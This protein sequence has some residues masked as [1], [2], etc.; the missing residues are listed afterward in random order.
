MQNFVK[1]VEV[2]PRDGLQNEA[3]LVPSEIKIAFINLLSGC[4][5][6]VIEATSFV[7]AKAI[8]QLA[9]NHEVLSAIHKQAGVTY[10][11]L[12]P[13]IQGFNA[14]LVAKAQEVSVFTAAS[15]SFTQKNINCSVEESL[16]RFAPIL[17][18][19][20][21]H[22]IA[23]RA[24]ISCAL[25]CPYEGKIAP[26]WV[27]ELA[28]RLF[29]MGCYEISLGDTIGIATPKQVIEVFNK[30]STKVPIES[31]AAHFHNTYGQA[32]ANLYAVLQLGVRTIDSAVAGLGGCPYAKGASGNVATE[33]VVYML[34]GLGFDTGLSLPRLLAA[35][36]F[37]CRYLGR[38][39]DS[40]L[41]LLNETSAS[42]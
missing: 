37:I 20:K 22:K 21:Q 38:F 10:P 16:M 42:N 2:A 24:Y 8:P 15:N 6:R 29:T 17:A 26:E 5:Y 41:A 27:A 31:L 40:K 3:L 1:I 11:V 19:A 18:A 9:D 4:G 32:L 28:Q 13:N 7:S 33:D 36:Q 35:G 14:A 39:P 30:V 34:E 25:G 12:V 23:V